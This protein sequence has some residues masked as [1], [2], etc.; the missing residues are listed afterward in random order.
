AVDG[1]DQNTH[2]RIARD[3]DSDH[4]WSQRDCAPQ[5][6][7]AGHAGHSLICDEQSD[8]VL[9]EQL[10]SLFAGGGGDDLIIP[11]KE[12]F[13]QAQIGWLVVNDHDLVR[14][15]LEVLLVSKRMKSLD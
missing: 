6:L 9:A 2:V 7:D 4:V 14:H 13:E 3:D 15:L 8:I 12:S 1:F 10:Q 5:K 11:A